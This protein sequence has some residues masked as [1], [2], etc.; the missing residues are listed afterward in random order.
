MAENRNSKSGFSR[1]MGNIYS[2]LKKK[3]E[4][5]VNKKPIFG[6]RGR[7][8]FVL[9]AF[10]AF[11]VFVGYNLLKFTVFESDTWRQL[12]NNQQMGALTIQANRGTIY[13][14]NGT[15]LAQSSTVWDVIISPTSIYNANIRRREAYDKKKPSEKTEP[16]RELSD[17]ICS[18]LSDILEISPDKMRAACDKYNNNYYYIVQRK[19]EKPTVA[20]IQEFLL[21]NDIK[22]DCVY[23]QQ[24]SKRYYPNGTLAS[25]VIGFTNFDGYGVYGLEAYYDD[26]LRGTDGK[27][28]YTKDGLGQ[29]IEYANDKLFSAVDGNSLVLTLDEVLQHYVEKNL[30]KC[31]SQHGVINRATAIVMNC[32]TGGVLAMATTPSFDPNDPSELM[33]EYSIKT[34]EQMIEDEAPEEEIAEQESILLEQQRKNKAV[35]EL[36]YPGSVFKTVTCAAALDE[37]LVNLNSTF[38]CADKYTV[39]GTDLHCW[40]HSGHGTLTLQEAITKSCNP[41]F[42]QIGQL[43]GSDKFFNY[44][45]AFG[46]TERTGI[47]LPGEARSLYVP[48]SRMG[49][50]ELA[51][52][53]FG[54]TNKITPI[55]MCTAICAIV[56]GGY[57]VTPHLVDKI[58]DSNGNVVETKST[59]IKRQVIS[60]DTSKQMRG[61][62]ETIVSQNGGTNAYIAGYRIGGKSGTA[63]RIDENN[64]AKLL[65]PNA[66]MTY[67]STF[68][69]AVPMDDP[70]IVMLVAAD[71]PTGTQYYGSAVAAPVVSAVF[72]EG[73]EHLGIY[74]TYTAEEQAEM[75][76]IVPYV[77]GNLSQKAESLLTAA[78]F[79]T[80]IIGDASSNATVTRQIPTSGQSIPKG[81]TVLLYLGN[82]TPE[83][84]TVPDVIGKSVQQAN[85]LIT[86]AGFNIKISGGAAQNINAVAVEQSV[87]AGMELNKGSVIEVTFQY[88]TQSD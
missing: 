41:S 32:K 18:G 26:Y 77:Q 22:S 15:V 14:A 21:E 83:K 39:A 81:S 6:Y 80:R 24:T 53:S 87:Y 45:E 13:D 46:F 42:I 82:E 34:I 7:Q 69:A 10:V 75:D 44:F 86:N 65:D 71:T 8:M 60:E 20:L 17:I 54:Q 23:T 35:T 29:G 11:S 63:E 55:Q 43:L 62:L 47:D 9:V 76:A 40:N 12:A 16:Y 68:A 61:I 37:E 3:D 48:R 74:P 27:A 49:P 30:E 66:P 19:V 85:E 78:G 64:A 36:Y 4:E 84:G 72:K 51:S 67:V 56:N 50:V 79:E 52:S 70:Q 2:Y 31:V 59:Q 57:L 73:L 28:F 38:V 33:G 5:E 25:T 88:N 1:V 58:I